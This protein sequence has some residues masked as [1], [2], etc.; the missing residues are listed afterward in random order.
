M[1]KPSRKISTTA[2]SRDMGISSKE[3]FETL[4]DL[5]LVYK[6]AGQWYL[7]QRGFDCGGE[8][9]V[10][11]QYGEYIVWP[12]DLDLDS[13]FNNAKQTLIN[14]T[15][16]GKEFGLTS[17]RI[18]LVLSE[19]G[20]IEKAI[21]G[22]T[23]TNLGVKAGGLEF[24][25]SSGGTYV[26]WPTDILTH[27]ALLSSIQPEEQVDSKP[28]QVSTSIAQGELI[29]DLKDSH[30]FREKFPATMRTKDG[31]LV[32]SRGEIL[33]DNS[34]Y[35][36]GLAHAYE[37]KLPIE[38]DVYCDFYIPSKNS[39]KAVYIEYWGMESDEKYDA[40]KEQKKEIYRNHDLNLIEIENKHI[41]NLDDYLPKMLL[42]YEIRVD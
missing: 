10:H 31:H 26:L 37:R 40:R 25:H 16:I 5:N 33:I 42:K 4:S 1:T 18:N 28:Q 7:T 17:Q 22:W 38:E 39:G 6:Q 24:E 34:L 29:A 36:Y 20:W 13:I 2:L 30:N 3:L 21:K 41:E 12:A 8:I 27:K 15:A 23:I 9:A 14:A 32:R 19:I 11:P 35:D